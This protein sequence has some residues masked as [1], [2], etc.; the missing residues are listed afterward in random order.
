MRNTICFKKKNFLLFIL[1]IMSIILF[2]TYNI[3]NN[4]IEINL[5]DII[6]KKNKDIDM[7]YNEKFTYH[8]NDVYNNNTI[9]DDNRVYVD[10]KNYEEDK[11]ENYTTEYVVTD[12]IETPIVDPILER[13]RNAINDPLSPPTRRQPRHVY[14]DVIYN[15][16]H[17]FNNPTRGYPDNYHYYGNL[18]RKEDEKIVKLF[19]R[20][21]YPNSNKY[22]YYGITT[23]KN[24][25]ELKI[26]IESK[27]EKELYD[28]DEININIL[29]N[30]ENSNKFKLYLNNMDQPYYNPYF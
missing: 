22:E 4:K 27:N 6:N 5:N 28:N 11:K 17:Y 10:T 25:G 8:D 26:N 9:N 21:T 23:D 30:T 20:Q 3:N 13:D 1:I 2:Y 19:G 15:N 18:V 29:N 14:N 7:N 24:G 12:K 16:K